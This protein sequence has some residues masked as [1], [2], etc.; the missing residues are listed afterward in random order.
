MQT[1]VDWISIS[2]PFI[3][4][5]APSEDGY[6]QDNVPTA[7]RATKRLVRWMLKHPDLRPGKGRA[8]FRASVHSA[9]GGWTYFYGNQAG[10][11]LLEITGS[12]CEAL[13]RRG[14]LLRLVGDFAQQV[15][16]ID[17]AC[18]IQTDTDPRE[19][20]E[21]KTSERFKS[22]GFRS[23][24]SGVTVYVGSKTSDRYARVY[25]YHAP[26]PR[27][28]LL[29][30]EHVFKDKA[31]KQVAALVA[32]DRLGE[33]VAAAGDLYG[34]HH[35][36]WQPEEVEDEI[37]LTSGRENHAGHTERWLLTQVLPACEKLAERGSAEF[38]RYFAEQI[39]LL[40]S[41]TES[42]V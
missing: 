33:V 39:I 36:T 28:H 27:A 17:I 5:V 25:R 34:W 9:I 1:I 15:T 18:D 3:S 10:F 12:G 32:A 7:D 30:V 11:S 38:L 26:H 8:P 29:R 35:A 19:F 40:T 2:L 23:S 20:A 42:E 4:V 16:R 21:Q 14:H 37:K 13:R 22:G 24:E 41:S 6:L 31:G